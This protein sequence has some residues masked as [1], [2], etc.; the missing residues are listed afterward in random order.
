MSSTDAGIGELRVVPDLGDELTSALGQVEELLLT[1]AVWESEDGAELPIPFARGR[2]L[3]ALQDVAEAVRP[4]QS[5]DEREPV[6]G[7]LLAPDGRYEHLPLRFVRIDSSQL[8]VLEHAAQLLAGPSGHADLTDALSEHAEAHRTTPRDLAGG[9]SRAVSVLTMAWDDDVRALR[10]AV[11]A[12]PSA[13]DVVL[14]PAEEAAYQRVA[15]R[16]NRLW[17]YGSGV[18]RFLY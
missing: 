14:S 5:R 10:D 12:H 7:R 9:L 11:T 8:D 3:T 2:A 18:D 17:S 15:E 4:T 6:P 1:L 13:T 16:L